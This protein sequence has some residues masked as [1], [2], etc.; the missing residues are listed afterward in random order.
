MFSRAGFWSYQLFFGREILFEKFSPD[1]NPL[2][3]FFDEN[4]RFVFSRSSFWSYQLCFWGTVR[5]TSLKSCVTFEEA[6]I[7]VRYAHAFTREPKSSPLVP[8]NQ[9]EEVQV[10][11][12]FRDV[13]FCTEE[14]GLSP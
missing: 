13:P 9:H 2:S 1:F 5:G 7:L 3:T 14:A 6:I 8:P 12:D 4:S 11:Q 10:A